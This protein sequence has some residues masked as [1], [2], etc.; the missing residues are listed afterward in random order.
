MQISDYKFGQIRKYTIKTAILSDAQLFALCQ[1]FGTEAIVARR[2]FAGLLPE[3]FKR[4]LY[5]KKG[6][7]SIYEFAAKLAG[8]SEEQV[9]LVL[10]LE[11]KF[12]DKPILKALLVNGEVSINKLVRVASIATVENQ[13]V[14]AQQ[15]KILPKAAID[16]LVRD[17]RFIRNIESENGLNKANSAH[18]VVYVHSNLQQNELN[19]NIPAVKTTMPVQSFA[20]NI[21]ELKLSNKVYEK[22][23][24]L[25]QKGIDVNELILEFL[26]KREMEIAQEKEE[27]SAQAVQT[28][29][30][31][32]PVK[33]RD[34]LKKEYGDRC[35]IRGCL[36]PSTQIHHAQRFSVGRTHD[37][38][39][40]APLCAQHHAIAHSV[41]LKYF[42]TKE[43]FS[44]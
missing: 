32:V 4:K 39:F 3:V 26:R 21:S 22:L 31:Y 18:E 5:L 40:L 30:R 24:E 9:R 43:L 7:H 38:K 20:K 13:E 29:S 2:K 8:M 28:E 16:T 1:K 12:D 15:V 33:I 36:K 34:V 25:Q 37:P 17:E 11:K 27:L 6:F 10:N 14:L 42:E 19:V 41:D 23:L 35:S 44:P